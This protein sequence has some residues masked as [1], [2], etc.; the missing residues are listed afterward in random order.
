MSDD[1]K[2]SSLHAFV[3]DVTMVLIGQAWAVP[4]ITLASA[5][6]GASSTA[7]SG[8]ACRRSRWRGCVAWSR[9][10]ARPAC[11]QESRVLK[12][13]WCWAPTGP[14]WHSPPARRSLHSG[15]LVGLHGPRRQQHRR[16]GTVAWL[17]R[18]RVLLCDVAAPSG[19]A[20]FFA[21]TRSCF[22]PTPVRVLCQSLR[23]SPC[24]CRR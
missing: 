11:A 1:W 18:A 3:I 24:S 21:D 6:C 4:S 14:I 9:S 10:V 23:R 7:A 22:T 8:T 17:R 20:N 16:T 5:S 19:F 2:G 15:F 13:R 12:H